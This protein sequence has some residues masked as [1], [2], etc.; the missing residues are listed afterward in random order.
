[1]EKNIINGANLSWDNSQE[2]LGMGGSWIGDLIFGEKKISESSLVDN[3]LYDKS[4]NRIFF[5]KFN[6]ITKWANDNFFSIHYY[7]LDSGMISN[8]NKAYGKAYLDSIDG[9]SLIVF[10]S[11]NN[12]DLSKKELIKLKEEGI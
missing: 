10:K 1:M 12:K 4:N 7:S 3:Y 2:I 5:V 9:E 6:R 8:L 11:F